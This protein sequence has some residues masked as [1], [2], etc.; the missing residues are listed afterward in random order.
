MERSR[1]E[2]P[3]GHARTVAVNTLAPYILT[4][5]IERPD[6][7]AY[8][9]SGMH[10]SG[11]GSLRDIDWTTRDWNPSPAAAQVY[12]S[13]IAATGRS[14]N[15]SSAS[16]AASRPCRRF[17]GGIGLILVIGDVL[18]V[19]LDHKGDELPVEGMAGHAL[20]LVHFFLGLVFQAIRWFNIQLLRNRDSFVLCL[21]VIG[22]KRLA[23]VLDVSAACLLSRELPKHSPSRRVF[24]CWGT[25]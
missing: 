19:V 4:A 11:S 9:S 12:T 8:L 24:R 13:W 20:E 10:Q 14:Q 23:E 16:A 2:T 21:A 6:R 18:L 15:A 22:G 25:P 5:L 3:E 7:L 1:G 17:V